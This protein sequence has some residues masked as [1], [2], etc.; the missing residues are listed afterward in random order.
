MAGRRWGDGVRGSSEPV[1][2]GTVLDEANL[3]RV[4]EL[5]DQGAMVS[6]SR[7]R[8]GGAVSVAV[9]FDGES[10]RE[11]FREAGATALQLDEWAGVI[12]DY[13]RNAPPP[14][15]NVRRRRGR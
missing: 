7:S 11:W 6:L 10:E 14:D 8:D 13:A 12:E 5:V 15:G 9:T 2:A 1:S 3:G 4:L